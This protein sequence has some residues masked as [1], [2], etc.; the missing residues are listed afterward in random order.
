MLYVFNRL[1]VR[2][3]SL[4]AALHAIDPNDHSICDPNPATC[5]SG[6]IAPVTGRVTY[7]HCE[8]YQGSICHGIADAAGS[9]IYVPPGFTQA[10]LE[11]TLRC[12]SQPTML[13]NLYF[14]GI[15]DVYFVVNLLTAFFLCL[16]CSL[17]SWLLPLA[18]RD[19]GCL[20]ALT[21]FL[22][23]RFFPQCDRTQRLLISTPTI[24]FQL[25]IV[26]P[27]LPCRSVCRNYART[28]EP[29]LKYMATA[30]QLPST[31]PQ[32][33]TLFACFAQNLAANCTSQLLSPP[34]RN[35]DGEITNIGLDDCPILS[36]NFGANNIS[37]ICNPLNDSTI[38]TRSLVVGSISCV[39]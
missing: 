37:T 14:C 18:P 30:S 27:R 2:N 38:C 23:G 29:M 26:L 16:C 3:A 24:T 31:D 35:C 4:I 19:D 15:K 7:G 22:C 5:N 10:G 6:P 39:N 12:A 33:A 21:K 11:S 8:V 28:C 17:V 25:P 9:D 20:D 32:T 34:L 1:I 36:T 13:D